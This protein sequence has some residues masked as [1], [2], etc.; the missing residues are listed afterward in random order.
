M[1]A[2]IE[3][4]IT[5]IRRAKVIIDMGNSKIP[6][7]YLKINVAIDTEVAKPF[8]EKLAKVEN[9]EFVIAKVENSITDVSDNLEVFI[10]TGEIDMEPIISKLTKQKEKLELEI[11]KLQE[12]LKERDEPIE[13]DDK[14]FN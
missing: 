13:F 4:A 11:K 12:R 7:A 5:A 14:T 8:I 1:F 10:P 9:I 2:I 6:K 3:E